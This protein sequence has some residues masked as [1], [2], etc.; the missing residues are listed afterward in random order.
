MS[1]KTL[2]FYLELFVIINHNPMEHW[3]S[4]FKD[5]FHCSFI[6]VELRFGFSSFILY[7][8]SNDQW[9]TTSWNSRLGHAW[10]LALLFVSPEKQNNQRLMWP[11]TPDIKLLARKLAILWVD[12]D[13]HEVAFNLPS[14]AVPGVKKKGSESEHDYFFHHVLLALQSSQLEHR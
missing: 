4:V 1:L 14:P 8:W 6:R 11:H 2:S 10:D 13:N 5:T 12:T 3:E 7:Y 9:Y